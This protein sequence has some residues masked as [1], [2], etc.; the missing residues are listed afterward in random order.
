M[1]CGYNKG[2]YNEELVFD[3]IKKYKQPVWIYGAGSIADIV[4]NKLL[5][6][7]IHIDG[8]FVDKDYWTS[9]L[10]IGDISVSAYE[11]LSFKGNYVMVMG[12]GDYSLAHKIEDKDPLLSKTFFL[13]RLAHVDDLRSMQN[14]IVLNLTNFERVKRTLQDD[15]SRRCLDAFIETFLYGDVQ[16][17]LSCYSGHDGFFDNSIYTLKPEASFLDIGA[18]V[19]DTISLFDKSTKGKFRK[20]WAIEADPKSFGRLADFVG[21]NYPDGRVECYNVCL[22]DKSGVEIKV[23]RDTNVSQRAYIEPVWDKNSMSSE[24]ADHLLMTR[25]D[26]VDLIKINFRG[27]YKALKGA[28][29]IIKDDKPKIAVVL[30]QDAECVIESIDFISKTAGDYVFFLRYTRAMPEL[31]TLFAVADYV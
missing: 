28:G 27:G 4:N 11:S 1:K 12:M 21:N 23:I 29:Q 14:E 3:E 6:H 24:T 5:E 7:D 22:W 30:G 10:R 9:E 2:F 16:T 18:Y 15:L 8:A 13:I 20:I 31:L 17:M 25:D 26:K 19:G